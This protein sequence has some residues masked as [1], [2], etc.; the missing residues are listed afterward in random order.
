MHFFPTKNQTKLKSCFSTSVQITKHANQQFI[1]AVDQRL[2][3]Y[4]L[5]RLVDRAAVLLSQNTHLSL[6]IGTVVC[7]TDESFPL[8]RDS[9]W[10]GANFC[11]SKRWQSCMAPWWEAGPRH[12]IDWHANMTRWLQNTTGADIKSAGMLPPPRHART[13]TN[14][15]TLG[16]TEQISAH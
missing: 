16:S 12:L 8:S 14:K 6:W 13:H 9:L 7:V 3:V 1:G 15:N 4:L 11:A 2:S 5:Y 10:G